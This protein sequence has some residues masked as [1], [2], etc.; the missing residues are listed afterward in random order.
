MSLCINVTDVNLVL[1]CSKVA[2]CDK[3]SI[4]SDFCSSLK[5]GG[6]PTTAITGS[7]A[8][9][10]FVPLASEVKSQQLQVSKKE[11][12]KKVSSVVGRILCPLCNEI[13]K[14]EAEF[15]AHVA[16]GH[17][18][19]EKQRSTPGKEMIDVEKEKSGIFVLDLAIN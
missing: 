6:K 13:C 14:D 15:K 5:G 2:I 8:K 12:S 3:S 18:D 9:E 17:D 19:K 16:K 1:L 10:P 11:E 7:W 4:K